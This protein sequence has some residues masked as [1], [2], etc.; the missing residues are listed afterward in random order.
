MNLKVIA[1]N[2]MWRELSYYAALSPHAFDLQFLEW[3][4]HEEPEALQREVQRAADAV[5]EKFDA[6]LLGYGFCSKGIEGVTAR[7]TK[8]VVVKGHD[9]ITHFLGSRQRYRTYFDENPGTY[10]YTPGWIENHPAPGKD[11]YEATYRQYVE[12]YG[13]DNAEYLMEMEQAWF[14]EY[15]TAAYIDCGVGNT[16]AYEAYTKECAE[17]LNWRFDRLEGDTGLIKRFVNGE[18]NSD[19]FLIVGPDHKIE[20]TNDEQVIRSVPV[21]G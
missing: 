12:Q 10:W 7:H 2:V 13:E 14:R 18:W 9:C 1:C 4:L 21:E 16:E 5:P 11:R 6:I 8:L 20:G 3:G 19:D 17:W 15:S